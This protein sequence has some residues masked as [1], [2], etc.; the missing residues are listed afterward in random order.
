MIVLC[1]RVVSE[2]SGKLLRHEM[3]QNESKRNEMEGNVADAARKGDWE[4]VRRLVEQG[5]NV[6]DVDGFVSRTALYHA[7]K[8]ANLSMCS[9]LLSTRRANVNQTDWDGNTLLHHLAAYHHSSRTAS[10]PL[11]VPKSKS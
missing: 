9:F 5:G 7:I 3:G 6:N 1:D 11:F 4:E 2:R 8:D 10:S